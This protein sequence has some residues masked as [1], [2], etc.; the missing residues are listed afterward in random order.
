MH[1]LVAE[2]F[3]EGYSSKKD[4]HHKNLKRN[5]NRACN[6]ICLTKK[7]HLDLHRQLR[8]LEKDQKDQEKIGGNN[9]ISISS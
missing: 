4:I 8:K 3:C 9:G 7:D 6:L 5:D 1:R 2:Y